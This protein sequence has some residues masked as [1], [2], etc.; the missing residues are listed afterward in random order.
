L[1]PL[2]LL[3]KSIDKLTTMMRKMARILKIFIIIEYVVK[4]FLM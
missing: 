3:S 1:T 4:K 2:L